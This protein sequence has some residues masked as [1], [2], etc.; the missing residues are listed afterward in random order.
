MGV[1]IAEGVAS[2]CG[3]CPLIGVA[4]ILLCAELEAVE[5]VL[6]VSTVLCLGLLMEGA[7][8]PTL[9]VV[10]ASREGVLN[11]LLFVTPRDV[12]ATEHG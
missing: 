12:T 10:R 4:N 2:P 7:L 5:L 9:G 11:R 8:N 1:V 6:G 3:V